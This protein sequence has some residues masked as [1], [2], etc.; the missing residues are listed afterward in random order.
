MKKTK[1][2]PK[3]NRRFEDK[4]HRPSD[5][6]KPNNVTLYCRSDLAETI[7]VKINI[8]RKKNLQQMK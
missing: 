2:K 5:R 7:K 8:K 3:D 6:E 4:R 1:Q